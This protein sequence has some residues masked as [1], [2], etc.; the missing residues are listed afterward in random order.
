MHIMYNLFTCEMN[1]ILSEVKVKFLP[2]CQYQSEGALKLQH[3]TQ[4]GHTD[5]MTHTCHPLRRTRDR[6]WATLSLILGLLN[7]F[8]FA[9]SLN[10]K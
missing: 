4:L 10:S 3:Q 7:C 1:L 8:S 6:K 5:K 9:L 2:A